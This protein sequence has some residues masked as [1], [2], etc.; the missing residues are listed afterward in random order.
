MQDAYLYALAGPCIGPLTNQFHFGHFHPTT[1]P[2]SPHKILP[3]FLFSFYTSNSVYTPS[4][5]PPTSY[6][7][8]TPNA[9]QLYHHI[10]GFDGEQ[11]PPNLVYI[12]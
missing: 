1:F 6:L 4:R 2:A 12:Y 7:L 5:T 3:F 8:F 9:R 10:P 11:T